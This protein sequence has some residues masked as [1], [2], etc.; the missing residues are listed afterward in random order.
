MNN[1]F[2]KMK[3]IAISSLVLSA[4]WIVFSSIM[5]PA[6]GSTI[7]SPQIGF[8]APAFDLPS[9]SQDNEN[10]SQ[11][12]DEVVL[13][14]FFASWCPPC[15]TEMPAMQN[16]YTTYHAKGLE[17]YAVTN[18]QQDNLS[19]IQAFIKDSGVQF[20]ILLDGNGATFRDFAIRALPTTFLLDSSG[21]IRKVFYGGPLTEVLLSTEI[22]KVLKGRR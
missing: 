1:L 22:E 8:L 13:V 18:L 6:Q 9:L 10:I 12:Q 4:G 7:S 17:I 3:W 15:K 2:A 11:N 5:I 16:V 21:R 19:D 20:P 14:N